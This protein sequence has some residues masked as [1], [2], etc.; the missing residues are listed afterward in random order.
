MYFSLF[1]PYFLSS[2][3]LQKHE[4]FNDS[5]SVKL[6]LG[7]WHWY[8]IALV[9]SLSFVAVFVLKDVKIASHCCFIRLYHIHS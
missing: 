2:F 7:N 4:Y 1:W 6:G 5:L 3:E 8:A 9:I